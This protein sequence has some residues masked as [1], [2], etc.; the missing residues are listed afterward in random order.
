MDREWGLV[1]EEVKRLSSLAGLSPRPETE[2]A[3]S[4]MDMKRQTVQIENSCMQSEWAT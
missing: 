4:H 3:P 1:W 2:A